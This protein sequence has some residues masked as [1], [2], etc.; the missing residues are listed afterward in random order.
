MSALTLDEVY[1]GSVEY[2]SR[3]DRTKGK[4]ARGL[5][6]MQ[7]EEEGKCKSSTQVENF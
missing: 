1:F 5:A 6:L 3:Y 2:P 4:R 7:D